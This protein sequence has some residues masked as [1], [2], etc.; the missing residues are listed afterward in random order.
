MHCFIFSYP[1]ATTTLV[2]TSER[3]QRVSLHHLLSLLHFRIAAAGGV[4]VVQQQLVVVVHIRVLQRRTAC[5]YS[6]DE[7]MCAVDGHLK[8]HKCSE[9]T[10]SRT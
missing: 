2:W 3:Q 8:L 1:A 9:L 10:V 6:R 5:Q 7:N 4:G